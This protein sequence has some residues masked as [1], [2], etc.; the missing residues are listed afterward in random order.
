MNFSSDRDLLLLEPQ[1]FHELP[2]AAQQRLAAHDA[3]LA[4]VTLTS[5][6]ADFL[7][8]QVES[9]SVVLVNHLAH[10]VVA[11]IDAHTLTLSLPRTSIGDPP[12]PSAPGDNLPLLART[13]APQAALVHDM[14]LRLL[15][16]D[17]DDPGSSLT[18][19]AIVSLAAM[20]RLESLGTLERLYT[21]AA[22]IALGD[23]N[24]ALFHKAGHYRERFA[25]AV[26]RAV[27]LLDTDGDGYADVRRSLNAVTLHRI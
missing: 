10:E 25:S 11:R 15:D 6:A 22:A 26:R 21:A 1:L 19:D 18:E 3:T 27:I 17:P 5:A 4:G 14:L 9:G 16:I 20:C 23:G 8:A 12:I 24:E 13:F 2:F 7:A